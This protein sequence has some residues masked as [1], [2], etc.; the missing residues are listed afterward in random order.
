MISKGNRELLG[1]VLAGGQSKR[2]G[3]DKGRMTWHGKEQRYYIADL[4]QDFCDTVYIS[5]RPEQHAEIDTNYNTLPDSYTGIGPYGAILSAFAA[6]SDKSWMIVACDLPLLDAGTIQHLIDQRD[7]SLIATT[8]KSPY[9][10]LPEPLITIWAPAS[11]PF[12]L[13]HLSEGFTCP[14]KV[15]LKNI[16]KVKIIEPVNPDALM[17]TNTPEDAMKVNQVLH[18]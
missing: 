5:C 13:S 16:D 10:G 11:H 8:Y 7:K 12:L 17:N 2:M 14:R 9:D 3:Q 1:L 6:H 15:L 4:L 18:G